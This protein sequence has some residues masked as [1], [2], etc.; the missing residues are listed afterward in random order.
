M[1]NCHKFLVLISILMVN[2]TQIS[3]LA[4][5]V[6]TGDFNK[7]FYVMWSPNHINTSS[8]GRARSLIL[9]KDSGTNC[10]QYIYINLILFIFISILWLWI[11]YHVGAGFA[12]N[13]MFLF[14]Q[15]DMQI[16]LVPGHSAGT[17]IAFYVSTETLYTFK[18]TNLRNI[19]SKNFSK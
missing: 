19:A 10:L 7:D 8:D 17:V 4:S 1:M 16:K 13:E 11:S 9:D 15:I 18:W 2:W 14:G 5:V 6:S 12:S 3:V